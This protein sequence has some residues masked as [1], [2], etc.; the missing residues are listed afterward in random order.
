MANYH[1]HHVLKITLQLPCFLLNRLWNFGRGESIHCLNIYYLNMLRNSSKLLL[2][3]E[4]IMLVLW[5]LINT[6]IIP[7][8]INFGHQVLWF[9]YNNKII[10]SAFAG[11]QSSKALHNMA[12]SGMLKSPIRFFDVTPIGDIHFDFLNCAF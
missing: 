6:K 1:Y 8:S 2:T 5:S 7:K 10:F 3:S 9:W 12:F 4:P 11:T